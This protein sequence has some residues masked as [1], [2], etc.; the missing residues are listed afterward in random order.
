MNKIVEIGEVDGFS[1]NGV[2]A[3]IKKAGLD[4]GVIVAD[5][6][7]TSAA[8]FTNNS[9]V[10]APVSLSQKNIKTGET[11]AIIVN[12]GNANCMT[13]EQ[14]VKDAELMALKTAEKVGCE[15][16]QVL[17]A[18]TGIIG[19]QLPVDK[20]IKGISG[21][22][23]ATDNTQA[24]SFSK[25]ILTT[26]TVRKVASS[27]FKI[28]GK[29]VTISGCAKGSGMIQPNMATMLA[30]FTTDVSIDSKMLDTALRAAC[31]DS[32][33][34][35][36]M[37]SGKA[38]NNLI[39][40]KNEDYEKF[41]KELS[42]LCKDLALLVVKDGEGATTLIEVEVNGAETK[43]QAKLLARSIANSPLVKTAANAKLPNWGRIAQAVGQMGLRI[44]EDNLK[45]KAERP[46]DDH[47]KIIVE[48][49]LGDAN[50]TIYTC[51]FT[52]EYIKINAEY[53]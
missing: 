8:L 3:G 25:S 22:V 31:E 40:T 23:Q 51:D 7:A 33:N 37:A 48:T 27:I 10:A 32:F 26:D 12:S 15:P 34:A 19:Y 30:F 21:A 17:V 2:V 18:S 41:V 39:E 46:A 5:E 24:D 52:E 20:V 44:T 13:G 4:V 47:V 38:A 42:V 36:I 9:I 43:E 14:G 35:T 16:S 28:D 11:R 45:T 53:N 49:N 29:E 6:P 50:G 1:A